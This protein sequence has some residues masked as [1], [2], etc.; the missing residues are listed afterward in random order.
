MW[1]QAK[2]SIVSQ[3]PRATEHGLEYD[4]PN[5][6]VPSTVDGE[7]NGRDP[8]HPGQWRRCRGNLSPTRCP[9]AAVREKAQG[10]HRVRPDDLS[11]QDRSPLAHLA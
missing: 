4:Q 6:T 9:R 1:E 10:Q 5:E 3:L 11:R 7:G 8:N 2:Q